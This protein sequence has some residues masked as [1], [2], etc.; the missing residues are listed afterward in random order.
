[1]LLFGYLVSLYT[2]VVEEVYPYLQVLFDHVQNGVVVE[3]TSQM[4]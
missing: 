2:A 1:M 3:P 4:W